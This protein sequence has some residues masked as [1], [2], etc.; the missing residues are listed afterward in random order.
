MKA[1][2]PATSCCLAVAIATLS[3]GVSAQTSA[4]GAA[5]YP[6]RQIR[7]IVPYTP[8]TSPDTIAR[9]LSSKLEAKLG[10]NVIVENKVGAASAIGTAYVAKAAP[11]GYTL[12]MSLNTH[13][14]T[15][16]YRKAPYDPVR[17]FTAIGQVATGQLLVLTNPSTPANNF[18]ELVAYI[19]KS[20]D[21]ATYSSPG[22]ASTT[23]LFSLVLQD[24]LGTKMRHIPAAGMGTAMMDVMQNNSTILLA[25]V[26]NARP[27]MASGKIKALAQTGK[28]RSTLLASL[29][30]IADSGYPD[31]DL[32]LWIGLYAPAGTPSAIVDKVNVAVRSVMDTPEMK[33][34][35]GEKG[36]DVHLSSPQEFAELT[37]QEFARWQK[38][39]KD[40]GLQA[41]KEK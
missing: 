2:L 16:A 5:A 3:S 7:L 6:N 13:V 4:D 41:D 12:M 29:P 18:Q 22:I 35:L 40:E 10:Q 34:D 21:N 32:S 17:D 38:V 8:G 15:P 23:H 37:R 39:I 30:S 28:K 31:Y 9:M 36:Y 33:R 24:A 25:G 19:K 27:L 11:D 20:G 14:I 1:L 26:E